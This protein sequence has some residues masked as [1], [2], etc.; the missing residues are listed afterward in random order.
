MT[1][2]PLVNFY[3]H[4]NKSDIQFAPMSGNSEEILWLMKE[5]IEKQNKMYTRFHIFGLKKNVC[6]NTP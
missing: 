4:E 1:R 3:V 5:G 2:L 6:P